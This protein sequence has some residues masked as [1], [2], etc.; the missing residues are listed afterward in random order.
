MSSL[1]F[2]F[3]SASSSLSLPGFIFPYPHPVSTYTCIA[4]WCLCLWLMCTPESSQDVHR[5]RISGC[6]AEAAG[7][8]RTSRPAS[9]TL[10]PGCLLHRLGPDRYIP[11]NQSTFVALVLR[12]PAVPEVWKILRSPSRFSWKN[13]LPAGRWGLRSRIVL[14]V[15]EFRDPP[16]VGNFYMALCEHS[17]ILFAW[18]CTQI[19]RIFFSHLLLFITLFILYNYLIHILITATFKHHL[20]SVPFITKRY[21][22]LWDTSLEFE[23]FYSVRKSCSNG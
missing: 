12:L 7:S 10:T 14:C 15:L 4:S 23:I 22:Y 16:S 13:A 20:L 6:E 11:I 17:V 9:G 3:S 1:P 21:F 5:C 18:E 2:P 19:F 8:P